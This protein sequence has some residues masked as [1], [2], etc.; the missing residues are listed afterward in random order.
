M[1]LLVTL[2]WMFAIGMLIALAFGAYIFWFW[3][4][5]QETR[6]LEE[7]MWETGEWPTLPVSQLH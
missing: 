1:T 6:T 5:G 2:G 3:A 7:R 4:T